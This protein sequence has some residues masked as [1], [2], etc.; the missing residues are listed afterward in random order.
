MKTNSL[1]Y[2]EERSNSEITVRVTVRLDDECKNGHEDFSVT[3]DVYQY[4][5]PKIDK[6]MVCCGCCHED[7]LQLFP[8]FKQ[9]V[10]LHLCDVNGAP[11]YAVSNGFYHIGNNPDKWVEYNH[12]T[13]EEAKQMPLVENEKHYQYLLNKLGVLDRWKAEAQAAIKALELLTGNE[14]K[15]K[16]TKLT[17]YTFT[18]ERFEELKKL[19]AS[20]Y[21]SVDAITSRMLANAEAERLKVLA[22]NNADEKEA[23][24]KI[25]REFKI[26]NAFLAIGIANEHFIYYDSS[27][28]IKFNWRGYGKPLSDDEIKKAIADVDH[29][30]LP[31][32]VKFMN[33][34]QQ[35]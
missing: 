33:N 22:K 12:L 28:T 4:G 14:F 9:F 25:K 29:K 34:L 27:N 10:D 16:A 30:Q 19:E 32:N 15:S 5:K 26:K 23:I 17:T 8:E 18:P 21:Y 3:A 35:L 1:I 13:Q 7:I 6:Y 24:A 20:G 2:K 31:K 11:M